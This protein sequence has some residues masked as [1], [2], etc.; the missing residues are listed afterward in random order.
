MPKILTQ[1]LAAAKRVVFEKGRLIYWLN[2]PA[3]RLRR[4][5]VTR[6]L[7]NK[8]ADPAGQTV[9]VRLGFLVQDLT[10]WAVIEPVYL[11]AKADPQTEP[12]VLLVT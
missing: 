11:A 7:K 12:L 8:F 9:K 6:R 3:Y 10:A 4:R 1:T 2:L 5:K